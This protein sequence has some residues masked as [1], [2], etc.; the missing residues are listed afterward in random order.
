MH[1]GSLGEAG[2]LC[3]L[4]DDAVEGLDVLQGPAHEDGVG[5]ALAVIGEDPHSGGGGGHGTHVGQVLAGQ[6]R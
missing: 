4:G 2:I 3:V 5:D 6:S 1:L